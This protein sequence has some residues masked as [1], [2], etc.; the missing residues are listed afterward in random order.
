MKKIFFLVSFAGLILSC[1]GGDKKPEAKDAAGEKTTDPNDLNSNPVYQ[2]GVEL[3]G[4]SD[5]LTCH[6]IEEKLTGPAYKDVAKKYAGSDTA[7]DFLARKIISGGG[8]NWGEILMAP[9][10]SLS[11]EDAKALAEYILLFKDK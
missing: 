9:H 8:G 1:G 5:C 4:K 11:M 7:V 6:R 2:K 10:P 3:I